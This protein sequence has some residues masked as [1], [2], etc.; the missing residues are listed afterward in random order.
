MAGNRVISAVLTL[1]DKDFGSTAKKSASAMTDFQRKTQHSANTVKSFGRSASSSF[2]SVATGA[3][4]I[5]AAIGVTRALSGA[6]N[7]VK[8]SV[9]SAFERIDTMESFERTITTLTGSTEKTKAA[10]EATRDAVT[11]TGY[12]LDVAA[13]SVQDFVTRG[14]EVEKATDAVAIWGD[15]VAF[16]GDGSNEQLASVSDALGKMYSSGKVGM[17]QMN[18]LFDAGIDGVG[19]YSKATGKDMETVKKG[20]SSGK[21]SAEDFLGVV[22]TAMEEG[23][24]GVQKIAGAAKEAGSTW[25][26]TFANMRA[27]VTRGVEG[28][29]V[30]IDEMLTSNGLPDMRS[31]VSDFGSNFEGV[32]GSLAE[33]IP[34][35][36]GFLVGMYESAKP[37]LDYI[38]D[39][40]MPAVQEGI[41]FVVEK[42]TEMYNFFVENWPMISP[43]VA[44]VAATVAAFRTGIVVITAA[45]ATWAAVTSGVQIATALLN[46]TLAISP[47]GWVALAIGAVVAA[48][49]LLWQNWDTVKEKAQLLWDKTKEVGAGIRDAFESA[50]NAVKEAAAN[51]INFVIDKINSLIGA[52]NKIP[53]VNV[54]IVAKVDWSQAS[55]GAT[56]ATNSSSGPQ[57]LASFD[58]GTNR[59][60]RDMVAQIHKD[61]MIV[62]A[63]QSRNL[64]KQGVTID[65]IDKTAPVRSASIQTTNVSNSDIPQ[66]IQAILELIQLLKNTA[67]GDV[68]INIDGYNKSVN[69]I[70]NELIPALKLRMANM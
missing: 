62:P 29:V 39:T 45:K 21:I 3:A 9:T 53:G 44:G 25:G 63:V 17:D 11:G 30:K 54:P 61:E 49:V 42:A 8:S 16:Y 65:N 69:E 58:V 7:M 26:N 4:S 24:N 64:R 2:K 27:A 12:G 68:V 50:W 14:M 31:M 43:V 22:G 48:G 19:M 46:G 20:L 66:L 13:K 56:A 35:I 34:A 6:F 32:L 28:I 5:A 70:I 57:R 1:K 47:L 41:G 38:K 67:K 37:G 52:I 15:A 23:T 55:G 40:A 33:K 59:V 36:T 10:L 60:Q 51:S 18:R